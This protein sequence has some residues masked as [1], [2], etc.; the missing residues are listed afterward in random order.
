M[1]F[2]PI[3]RLV[4]GFGALAF[5]GLIISIPLVLIVRAAMIERERRIEVLNTGV[6]ASAVVTESSSGIS[7]RGC[8][9][10]YRFQVNGSNFEGGEGGCPLVDT[11]PTGS[12]LS[13]RFDP[14]DPQKSVAVGA[15]LWPGWAIVPV[16]LALPLILLG[17]V[18]SY[19][20]VRDG[21][22]N[23]KR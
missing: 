17:G 18:I 3:Q 8:A 5:L 9:F 7:T 4:K 22:R 13:I 19:A 15:E 20:I 23:P 14:R 16:L 21:F 12:S 6:L 10:R 2:R 1:Q 11:H